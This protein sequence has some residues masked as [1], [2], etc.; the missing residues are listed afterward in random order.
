[1]FKQV[2][3]II[4]GYWLELQ[5]ITTKA[6]T[7]KTS[8]QIEWLDINTYT[9]FRNGMLFLKAEP[10]PFTAARTEDTALEHNYNIAWAHDT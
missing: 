10:F 7:S 6:E 3:V 2:S 8:T 5:I 4:I 1:M 9:L